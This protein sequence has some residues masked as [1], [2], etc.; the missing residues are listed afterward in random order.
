[1]ATVDVTLEVKSID[2]RAG[3]DESIVVDIEDID[4]AEFVSSVDA[5]D[6]L[7]HLDKATVMEYFADDPDDYPQ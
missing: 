7:E 3:T 6:L 2:I 1:M 5:S 4:L